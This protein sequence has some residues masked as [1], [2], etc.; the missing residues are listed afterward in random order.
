MC[1]KEGNVLM[2]MVLDSLQFVD[3]WNCPAFHILLCSIE[4][5]SLVLIYIHFSNTI[6]NWNYNN[7]VYFTAKYH[8]MLSTLFANEKNVLIEKVLDLSCKVVWQNWSM[9]TTFN[10]LNRNSL[11]LFISWHN[12]MYGRFVGKFISF[13]V[14]SRASKP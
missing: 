8:L 11:Y 3:V 7:V 9:L 4:T 12:S 10:G 1:D 2:F 13:Y 14:T 5:H 6:P